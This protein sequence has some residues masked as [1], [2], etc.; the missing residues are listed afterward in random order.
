MSTKVIVLAIAA[1]CGLAAQTRMTAEIPFAFEFNGQEMAAGTYEINRAPLPGTIV[2]RNRTAGTAVMAMWMG[3]D[4]KPGARRG[5]IFQ[6][7]GRSYFLR[8]V[9]DQAMETAYNVPVSPKQAELARR[10]GS[11]P[12][13][14]AGL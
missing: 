11:D 14:V 5:L 6:K 8:S 10:Q 9:I 7:V 2:L 13:F 12:V 1:S 4:A 3:A